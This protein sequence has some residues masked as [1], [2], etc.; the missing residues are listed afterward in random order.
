MNATVRCAAF[1][2]LACMSMAAGAKEVD[3]ES[4]FIIDKNWEIVKATC[5]ACHSSKLVIGQRGSRDTWKG[6]IRWMQATQGLWQFE[7]KMEDQILTYL[8]TN[9]PPGKSYRRKPLSPLLMPPQ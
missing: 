7:P 3:P 6:I 2:A 8:A 4:G 9:Y 5:T 1:V